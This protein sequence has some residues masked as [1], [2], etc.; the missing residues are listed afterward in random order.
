MRTKKLIS[1]ISIGLSLALLCGCNQTSSQTSTTSQAIEMTTVEVDAG[2]LVG[3]HEDSIY[4]FKGIPYATAERFQSPQRITSYEN[5]K[6][7]AFTYGPVSPQDR[8]LNGTGAVN[9]NEFMTPSNGTADMVANENCQYLNVWSKDLSGNKP[10]VVFFHGGGLSNGASSELSYYTGE[11]FVERE[12]AVFVSVNHRLNVLGYLDLSEYGEEYKDSGIVGIQDCVIALQWVKDNIKQ[13]GGD[14]SNV[15]IVGQ[16]GG[17]VKVTTLACMSDTVDLFNKVVVLSGSYASSADSKDASLAN[18]QK[19][20]DSLKLS[21]DKVISTL[22]NMSYEELYTSATNAGCSWTTHY[23]IGTFETPLFDENGKINEY[24]AKRTWMIGCT[25]SEFSDNGNGLIYGQSQD[26]YLPDITDE[27]ALQRLKEIYGDNADKIAE[28]YK[29]AYPD[30]VLADALFMN[31]MPVGGL[32]RYGLINDDS[33][34]LKMFNDEGV[35]VY[36]YVVAYKQP[37]FG[38]VTMHHTAD[39]PYWFNALDEIT[40]QIKGDETNAY[41]I[42]DKMA[43]TLASFM[44]DGNPSINDLKWEAYT[45]DNH[46]TMVFDTK[47]ECRTDFDKELYLLIMSS[48]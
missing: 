33:G 45:K 17:G 44:A 41:A 11:H 12:D 1:M 5:G 15:T 39:I 27:K 35:T 31:T 14:P 19:L 46:S 40:Y 21:K 48:L 34:I 6:Q 42:S 43:D 22:T 29:Q 7:L 18:T 20:V 38:G 2:K 4:S 26:N 37:Y 16:S 28:L 3:Y 36:N 8:C 23:G 47:S 30:H 9:S 24:A 13:F 10:V 25:Y 32:S